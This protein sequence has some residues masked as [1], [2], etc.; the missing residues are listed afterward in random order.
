M[1]LTRLTKRETVLEIIAKDS[2]KWRD[3]CQFE[4][5]KSFDYIPSML[6]KGFESVAS[7]EDL[8]A[9]FSEA[10]EAAADI[11]FMCSGFISN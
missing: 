7:Q 6:K 11:E 10:K 4:F 3:A 1:L 2:S 9:H 5:V 8:S